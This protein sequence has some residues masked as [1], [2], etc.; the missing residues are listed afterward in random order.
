M[1]GIKVST[2]AK[3]QPPDTNSDGEAI[4][5]R[6]VLF[7]EL[8]QNPLAIK[9]LL[10]LMV[11]RNFKV[12]E[13]ILT[14]GDQGEDFFVL[15]DGDVS[16][17]KKTQEGDLY[18]VAILHGHMGIFFGEGALLEADTRTATIQ[19]DTACRCLVLNAK[20]FEKFCLEHPDWAFPILKRVA[21]AIMSRLKNMN[22]DLSLLYKALVDEFSRGGNAAS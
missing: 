20:D 13:T 8:R 5:S 18:K 6:V 21:Q 10:S 4:V 17:Y 7:T 12:G 1:K 15:A 22:R 9:A 3:I 19:A 16:V 11:E 2:V 14:E